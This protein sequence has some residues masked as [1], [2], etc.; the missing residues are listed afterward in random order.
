MID[1]VHSAF[2]D[3]TFD[4]T[5]KVE[6]ILRHRHVWPR[7]G[8]AGCL[9]AV[10]AF[11]SA[12]DNILEQLDK[13]HSA[14]EEVE[15][16]GVLRSAGIE[17]RPSLLPFTPWTR[18]EDVFAVLDLVARC[19]LVGN[20][21]PVQ[22]A[23][24]LLVPPGSLL[25]TSGRLEGRLDDYDDEHLGWTWRAPDPRLDD[26]HQELSALAE[27]AA[28]E[29]WPA[30]E[31]Y[32]A[33]RDAAVAVLGLGAAHTRRAPRARRQLRGSIPADERP[34]L[35]ESWFCCAEPSGAQMGAVG[36]LD[37]AAAGRRRRKVSEMASGRATTQGTTVKAKDR[38]GPWNGA[39][40]GAHEWVSFPDPE[41]ERTWQFD[42]T[43]LESRWTCIFGNG[44]QGVLTGPAP[45]LVQGCCSYG[46]HF[47]GAKDA[48]RV[49]AAAATLTPEQWQFHGKGQPHARHATQCHRQVE[50][51]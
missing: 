34:R 29:Q 49:Q 8:A 38:H 44:C 41:E 7:M 18:P 9:F 32:D 47:T 30:Q 13:G 42:V 25:V 16:V 23:I 17:P 51:R 39:P 45:E 35:T 6:H 3:V 21:D 27:R 12:S 50:V 14:A 46:A 5:V 36:A 10:S 4:V 24:R 43:F 28:T 22:Y 33:V 40:E 19:D 37:W 1:A 26:L 48:R 20:V 31:C 2:P 11:E 15:A